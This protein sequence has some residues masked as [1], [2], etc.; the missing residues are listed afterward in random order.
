MSIIF[1]SFSNP[2]GIYAGADKR[3]SFL[4]LSPLHPLLLFKRR[5]FFPLGVGGD[6]AEIKGSMVLA[7][8]RN[9]GA[10]DIGKSMTKLA[11][12]LAA[13]SVSFDQRISF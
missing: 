10:P 2:A 9:R 11:Y 6:A 1:V 7:T 12:C 8:Y 13:L 3:G 5:S 4:S